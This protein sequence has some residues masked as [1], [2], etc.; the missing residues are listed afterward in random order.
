[1]PAMLQVRA[2]TA[3]EASQIERLAHSRKEPVRRV[4]RAHVIKW[5]AQGYRVSEIADLVGFSPAS[6]RLWIKRF[7]GKGIAGLEDEPRS[8]RPMTYTPEQVSAVI[9][10]AL[11]NPKSLG[12]PFACW[13]LDRLEA[14]LNEE[15]GIEMKRSRIDEILLREGLR[16]R[17]HETW[18][19][20]RVDPEFAQ[21]RGRSSRSTR[22]NL[23]A[24]S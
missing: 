4:Q 13:T 24:V 10:T 15:R 12:L 3:E 16:W 22:G 7:N 8:G 5:S 6:V 17:A 11:T 20:E 18:F 14:Y 2:L 21:K 1:M 9:E 23:R 19:S